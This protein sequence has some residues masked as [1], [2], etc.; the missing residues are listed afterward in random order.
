MVIPKMV[1]RFSACEIIVLLDFGIND[2][3]MLC[4]AFFFRLS[5]SRRCSKLN[6]NDGYRSIGLCCN[7]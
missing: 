1:I 2:L 6:V 5:T 3:L 4:E 7:L